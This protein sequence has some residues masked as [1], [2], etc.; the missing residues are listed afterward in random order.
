MSYTIHPQSWIRIL[1]V[2]LCTL[3]GISCQSKKQSELLWEAN[4]HLIGSQSSP[5]AVD[6]TQDGVLDIVIGAGRNEF[7]E[8]EQGVLAI[9]GQDGSLIWSHAAADQIYGSATFYDITD[10][11]IPDVFIGGRSCQFRAI[12]GKTGKLIWKYENTD[13]NHPILRYA[14]FNFNHSVQI[15]DQNG[16]GYP[17]LLLSN[18]GNYEALPYMTENRFP[19]VIMVLDSKTGEVLA[20][21][22]VPDGQESYMTPLA[23]QQPW[24]SNPTVVFGTGGETLDGSLFLVSLSDLMENNLSN[25]ERIATDTGHGFIAPP[26]IADVNQDGFM[27]IIAISHGSRVFA[28]DGKSRETIW[29][30]HISHTECSNSF[31]VGYFTDDD[32]PDFFTFVSEGIWP[33]NT[34][35]I[36]IMLDGKNGDISYKSSIGCTGFSSPVAI[37]LNRDGREEVILSVNEFDCNRFIGDQSA[38]AITNRLIGIDFNTQETFTLDQTEGMKNIFSTPWLGDM[39]GDGFLDLVHCQYFSHSDLL[40]FLGMRMKRID[41]PIRIRHKPVWGSYMGKKGDGIFRPNL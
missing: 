12:D 1:T 11:G 33:E 38:F 34:G 17:E 35:S 19:A 5:R 30:Q 7:Q 14:R 6:L 29:T 20:A 32:V 31:A 25:A 13:I 4:F 37:D 10:D 24:E 36:Q 27:D 15:A 3:I 2:F 39:D 16:N 21:D 23:F 41:L 22:T 40:S 26:A 28:I 9:N 18:G 8:T